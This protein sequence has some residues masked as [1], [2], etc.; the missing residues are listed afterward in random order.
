[1]NME[2]GFVS[3][4]GAGD[5]RFRIFATEISRNVWLYSMITRDLMDVM[6]VWNCYVERFMLLVSSAPNIFPSAGRH[7]PQSG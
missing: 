5:A 2:R 3:K 6:M 4:S 1:V 7:S